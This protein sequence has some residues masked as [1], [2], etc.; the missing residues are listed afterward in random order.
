M[1]A[2]QVSGGETS[3][4]LRGGKCSAPEDVAKGRVEFVNVRTPSAHRVRND[5][6]GEYHVV[7]FEL[8]DA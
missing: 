3:S 7:L 2:V 8:L 1:V 6:A 5:G 4:Q